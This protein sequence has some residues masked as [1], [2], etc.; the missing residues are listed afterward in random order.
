MNRSKISEPSYYNNGNNFKQT[1]NQMTA[2]PITYQQSV[3]T[4]SFISYLYL[5]FVFLLMKLAYKVSNLIIK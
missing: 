2:Q 3:S 4:F 1:P 5:S